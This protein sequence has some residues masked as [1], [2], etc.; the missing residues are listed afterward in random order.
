MVKKLIL[1]IADDQK[2]IASLLSIFAADFDLAVASTK[3]EAIAAIAIK[4][5]NL[6]LI[7]Y[8]LMSE[9]GLQVYREI[10]PLK[11]EVHTIMFSA[12]NSIPLA[13]M[14]TKA[15]VSEFLQKPFQ[16][17]QIKEAVY[18]N[19]S[20]KEIR[21]IVSEKIAWLQGES[22]IL[23]SL[24]DQLR[25]ALYKNADLLLSA[26]KGID[27]N[28]IA[29]I[30]HAS[31]PRA[32]RKLVSLDLASFKKETLEA[33]FWTLLQEIM[34]LPEGILVQDEKDRC[35][36]LFLDNFDLTE[37]HFRSGLINFLKERRKKI[38]KTIR[39]IL[40]VSGTDHTGL[41]DFINI[42]IP[43][44][45]QRKEDLPS[46]FNVYLEEYAAKYNK[47]VS[48]VSIELIQLLFAGEFAGNYREIEKLIE[49]AVLSAK[50]DRL[51]V[52]DFPLDLGS[53]KRINLNNITERELPL[54][55]A[56]REFE[57]KLY[58]VLLKKTNNDSSVMARFLDTPRNVLTQRIE[59][60]QS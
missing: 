13:V 48:C 52:K 26:E 12:S 22:Q 58:S 45:R 57:N 17:D 6:L 43:P 42:T 41:A 27:K 33:N 28:V 11:S 51:E 25:D 16:A 2:V 50:S 60:L 4:D 3:A 47:Q 19:L 53:L 46:I 54:S 34:A 29:L 5:P 20:K 18:R 38:D 8:D 49:L 44:L 15:G 55:D 36:T 21:L 59:D 23:Q 40:G 1:V 30:F 37:E 39:V 24:F 35:G 14:A 56:K 31:G 7:D 10:H 9:D 32:K